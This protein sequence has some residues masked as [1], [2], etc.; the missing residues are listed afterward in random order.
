M[1]MAKFKIMLV[2]MLCVAGFVFTGNAWA[3]GD[4][5]A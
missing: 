5:G 3:A 2:S 4:K 1:K